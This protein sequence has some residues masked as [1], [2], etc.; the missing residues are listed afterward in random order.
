M[1]IIT[2]IGFIKRRLNERSTWVAIGAGCAGAAALTSPFNWIAFA[3][4]IIG[5]LVPDADID[6]NVEHSHA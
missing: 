1:G 6:K 5:A 4:G 3:V 2:A